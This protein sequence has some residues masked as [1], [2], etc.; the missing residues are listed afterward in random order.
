MV[1]SETAGGWMPKPRNDSVDSVM[2]AYPTTSVVLTAIGP[3][4]FGRMWRV[5]IRKLD[6]PEAFAASTYSFSFRDKKSPRVTRAIVCQKRKDRIQMISCVELS[7]PK[8]GK[9]LP[10]NPF[11]AMARM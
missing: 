10:D 9:L 1:P 5:M 2:M 6:A 3:T 4:M 7:L 8:I 11:W